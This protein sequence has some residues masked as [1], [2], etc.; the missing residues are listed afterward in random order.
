[1][2]KTIYVLFFNRRWH[3]WRPRFFTSTSSQPLIK[4]PVLHI[5]DRRSI[6]TRVA[7]LLSSYCFLTSSMSENR[8]HLQITGTI[9]RVVDGKCEMRCEIGD[10]K[11]LPPPI[12][13]GQ[14]FEEE[15]KAYDGNDP[16]KPLLM[17]IKG[18]TY[19]VYRVGILSVVAILSPL[20]CV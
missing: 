20:T 1:M 2:V 15:L 3:R 19:D 7:L 18:Q 9:H 17:A 16:Q 13:F 14:I 8:F 4:P 11:Y 12:Q 5:A 6:S 10:E